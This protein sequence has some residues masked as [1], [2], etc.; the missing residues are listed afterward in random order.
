MVVLFYNCEIFHEIKTN[1]LLENY[2]NLKLF[3]TGET[4]IQ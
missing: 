3:E 1:L 2:F 4:N